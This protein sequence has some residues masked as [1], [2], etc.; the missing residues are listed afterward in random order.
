MLMKRIILSRNESHFHLLTKVTKTYDKAARH[1]NSSRNVSDFYVETL[2]FAIIT[3]KMGKYVKNLRLLH[4][5]AHFQH[6]LLSFVLL[7]TTSIL[8][9]SLAFWFPAAAALRNKPG[10]VSWIMAVGP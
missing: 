2:I 3:Y 7:L 8:E 10:Q 1:N 6:C 4:Y 9:C 5:F